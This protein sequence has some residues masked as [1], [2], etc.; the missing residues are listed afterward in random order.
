MSAWGMPKPAL[1]WLLAA[2]LDQL[3]IYQELLSR[4]T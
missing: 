1:S 2:I 4:C 3:H